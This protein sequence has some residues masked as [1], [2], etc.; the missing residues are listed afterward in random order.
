M[1]I[2]KVMIWPEAVLSQK[3]VEVQVFD[4]ALEALVKDMFDTMYDASGVG[5][6]APQVG[7]SQRVLVIDLNPDQSRNKK[8]AEEL[9]LMGF[10]GPQT[11]INPEI[12]AS[13]GTIIW[14]EGCLSVPEYVDEVERAETVTVRAY[15][16]QGQVFEQTVHN[17]FAVAIQ[18]ELDHLNGKVFVEYLSKNKRDKVKQQMRAITSHTD[19]YYRDRKM[20]K[21]METLPLPLK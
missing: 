11:F 8:M 19:D 13:S 17:L 7:V 9:L 10:K 4:Q 3:A 15:D 16:L 2:R 20:Q 1:A 14:E 6:A 5:L 21:L 18:H 12:I